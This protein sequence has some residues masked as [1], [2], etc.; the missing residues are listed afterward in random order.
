MSVIDPV[1]K[2]ILLDMSKPYELA[3]MYEIL[4]LIARHPSYQFGPVRYGEDNQTKNWKDMNFIYLEEANVIF[5]QA[6]A[7][8]LVKLK[9]TVE[10]SENIELCTKYF[11]VLYR[12]T[13]NFNFARQVIVMDQ[14]N[15]LKMN[16]LIS[17]IVWSCLCPIDKNYLR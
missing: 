16:F 14:E 1:C 17:L 9:K 10:I 6:E 3:V 2:E 5:S 15:Y 12:F 7:E 8:I 4:D 13:I 11:Q